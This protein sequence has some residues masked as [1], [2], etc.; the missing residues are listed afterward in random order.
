MYACVSV[1]LYDVCVGYPYRANR[2][3]D[4]LELELGTIVSHLT[5]V[6]ETKALVQWAISPASACFRDKSYYVVYNS[7]DSLCSSGWLR[8]HDLPDSTSRVGL[9]SWAT[10]LA[11][12]LLQ[13]FLSSCRSLEYCRSWHAFSC[14]VSNRHSRLWS[15]WVIEGG[16]RVSGPR[17]KET[18][19]GIWAEY[20]GGTELDGL[21]IYFI[22]F[23]YFVC[24]GV[25]P[26]YVYCMLKA[27]KIAELLKLESSMVVS[28][29]VGARNMNLS[30]L[31]EQLGL[32]STEWSLLL[33]AWFSNC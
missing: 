19:E 5:W 12:E 15:E 10:I 3:F 27:K 1:W 32:L 25:L 18:G 6:L 14:P 21:V 28:H 7:L 29:H 11:L 8:I 22:L 17:E 4:P 9:Q 33:D 16:Q 31:Q 24:M 13:V 2:V 23:C 20:P 30:S 26:P